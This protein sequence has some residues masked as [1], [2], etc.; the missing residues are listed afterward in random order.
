[1][2]SSALTLLKLAEEAFILQ[3]KDGEVMVSFFKAAV[4]HMD[5]QSDDH[6]DSPETL[7]HGIAETVLD[8]ESEKQA[9]HDKKAS[10]LLNKTD[11]LAQEVGL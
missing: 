11:R 8:F 7:D 9:G 10:K 3:R 2:K 4:N 6:P 1:M 5:E